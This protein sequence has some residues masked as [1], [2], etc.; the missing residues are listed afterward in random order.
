[1]NDLGLIIFLFVIAAIWS[2]IWKGVALWKSARY[3]QK[4]W[5]VVLLIVNTVGL[6]E[7]IYLAFF[8]KKP[9]Q[10]VM[11]PVRP[12]AAPPVRKRPVRKK[13]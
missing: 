7:I 13:R 9:I 11:Q 12:T 6:L 2:I 3:G 4:A 8:Q 5:F 10:R 1:M